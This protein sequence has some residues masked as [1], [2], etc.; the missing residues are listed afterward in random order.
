MNK[1]KPKRYAIAYKGK[2]WNIVVVNSY[3]KALES[4]KGR[5]KELEIREVIE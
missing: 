3:E 5:E 2:W 4:I 1:T